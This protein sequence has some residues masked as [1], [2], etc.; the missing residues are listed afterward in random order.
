MTR[1]RDVRWEEPFAFRAILQVFEQ[2]I[3]QLWMDG[4]LRINGCDLFHAALF[5]GMSDGPE[6][7]C[8]WL[9]LSE[10]ISLTFSPE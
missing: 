8:I 10:M 1:A 2:A 6:G 4:D 9:Y 5:H 3:A 7:L